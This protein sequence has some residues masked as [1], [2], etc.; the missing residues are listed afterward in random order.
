MGQVRFDNR[1]NDNTGFEIDIAVDARFRGMGYAT[2]LIEVGIN[3]LNA[4]F[5]IQ[6]FHAFVKPENVASARAFEKVGFKS[7]GTKTIK[8]QIATHYIWQRIVP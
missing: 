3:R 5:G 1:R 2:R 8:G 4:E 6:Q 7:S